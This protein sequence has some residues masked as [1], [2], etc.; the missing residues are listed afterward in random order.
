VLAVSVTL[1]PGQNDVALGVIVGTTVP[2]QHWPLEHPPEHVVVLDWKKHPW[3]SSAQVTRTAPEHVVAFELHTESS[4]QAQLADP[5]L[6]VHDWCALGH[7]WGVPYDRQP[8]PPV[9]Q[10]AI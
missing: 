5:G 8:L 2:T 10:L 3:V 9:E 6:P 4:M 7:A 1:D